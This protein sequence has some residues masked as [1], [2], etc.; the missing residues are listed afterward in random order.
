MA[1]RNECNSPTYAGGRSE[2]VGMDATAMTDAA[3]VQLHALDGGN[4][5]LK[6]RYA[7]LISR[8]QETFG[9]DAQIE[10]VVRAPGRVN[11]IGEHI[12]YCGGSV[13]PM[14]IEND[15]LVAGARNTSSVVYMCNTNAKYPHKIVTLKK[16]DEVVIDKCVVGK[17]HVLLACTVSETLVSALV[18]QRAG[19]ITTGP[20]TSCAATRASSM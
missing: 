10:F 3:A 20:I 5:A 11:L 7:G 1:S 9:A 4:D 13:L 6:S 16:G 15:V 17:C 8:F 14:C 2:R 12:D 18:V 19:A